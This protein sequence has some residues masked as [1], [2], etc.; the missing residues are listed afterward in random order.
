MITKHPSEE[1]L[2]V[3]QFQLLPTLFNQSLANSLG[4]LTWVS[5]NFFKKILKLEKI[6]VYLYISAIIV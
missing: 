3:K 6:R 4:Q 2:F 5:R 1:Y